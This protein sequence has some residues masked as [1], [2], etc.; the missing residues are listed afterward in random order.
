GVLGFRK[1]TGGELK[2]SVRFGQ[3]LAAWNCRFEGA[4]GGMY[5][6]T[7]KDF[8]RDIAHLLEGTT[9]HARIASLD[10]Q[11]VPHAVRRLCPSCS[12][13]PTARRQSAQ[14]RRRA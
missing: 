5:E 6:V 13:L 11:D 4:R 10:E 1:I 7:K 12:G 14:H 9:L 2:E 3:A 8:D